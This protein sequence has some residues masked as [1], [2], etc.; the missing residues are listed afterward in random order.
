MNTFITPSWVTTDVAVNW[1]NSIKLVGRFD[2]SWDNQWENK[3]QG[4]QIGFTVQARL[5]PRMVVNEGQALVQQPIINQTVPISLNHQYQVGCGWSSADDA[6]VVE[7]A[8]RYTKASGMALANKA[9][10]QAGAEVYKSVYYS[11]GTPGTAITSDET[12]TDGVA[13]LRQQGVPDELCAVITPQ[14]QSKLLAA[15]FALFGKQYQEYFSTGQFSAA[16]LGVD[17]WYW[18]PNMPT[19]TTG[20]FTSSTP[21][22]NGA[23]QTGSTLITDGWGTYAIKAGD[24]FTL[25]GVNGVNPLSYADSGML[26]QFSVQADLAGS[27]TGTFTISPAIITSGQLQTV[28]NSPADNAAITFVGSTGSVSATMTATASKQGL[29]FNTAAFAFVIADLP[30]RL[31]GAMAARK[32]DKDA[33]LSMRWAEQYN[34]QTDQ[35]PSRMDMIVGVAPVLPYFALRCYA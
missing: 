1:K 34:I 3:P 24:I 5:S 30:V 25:A 22:V 10:V 27:T 13:I 7:E 35:M 31:A 21:A 14:A 2:R 28:M 15:N 33:K 32:N 4:A 16:A 12:Y 17:D 6:L 11:I 19:H 20:S 9:D 8:Q 29:I 23:L 26:Q 18:D